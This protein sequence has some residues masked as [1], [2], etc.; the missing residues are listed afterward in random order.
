MRWLWKVCQNPHRIHE[1]STGGLGDCTSRHGRHRR[2]RCYLEE[3][4]TCH[5]TSVLGLLCRVGISFIQ[6]YPRC[7]QR[8]FPAYPY[9]NRQDAGGMFCESPRR[10]PTNYCQKRVHPSV[11]G[12]LGRRGRGSNGRSEDPSLFADWEWQKRRSLL[13]ST[14]SAGH[15]C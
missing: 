8:L 12:E 2:R 7:I 15:E 4:A 11:L 3:E 1:R 10:H 6:D 5:N 9:S 13:A 14:L